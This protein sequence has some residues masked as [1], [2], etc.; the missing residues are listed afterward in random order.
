MK[1]EN[2]TTVKKII[3][4]FSQQELLSIIKELY[5]S[6]KQNKDFLHIRFA[7]T[8]IEEI[9]NSY[10]NKIEKA[11]PSYYPACNRFSIAKGK[12]VI[13]N[14][15]KACKNVYG[16]CELMLHFI[17]CGNSYTLA[18]GDIDEGFYISMENM[19]HALVK[20]LLQEGDKSLIQEFYEKLSKEVYSVR[21]MGWGYADET[22]DALATLKEGL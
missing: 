17:H 21:D 14:F 13:S 16:E 9:V 15:R 20:K 19:H 2:W 22:A 11:M 12:A 8:D 1:K 4:E 3:S 5:D 7:K 18:F 6:N 10:K